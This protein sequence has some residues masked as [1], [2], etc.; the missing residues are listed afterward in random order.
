M[1][2]IAV[3]NN[4]PEAI[5]D[6]DQFREMVERDYQLDK[7][8]LA[9]LIEDAIL[10][11]TQY[12][13]LISCL[14]T[15]I[16]QLD[17]DEIKSHDGIYG[18]DYYRAVEEIQEAQEEIRNEIEALQSNSRKGNT[19]ADIARRLDVIVSNMNHIL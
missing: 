7:Q 10:H 9:S 16:E 11:Y 15:I 12:P 1:V 2:V 14:D 19:K 8:D 6:Y 18:D 4:K 17:E 5:M 3:R 13:E